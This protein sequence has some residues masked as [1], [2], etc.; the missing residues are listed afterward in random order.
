MEYLYGILKEADTTSKVDSH[1]VGTRALRVRISRLWNSKMHW[2]QWWFLFGDDT[3]AIVRLLGYVYVVLF[4]LAMS[5]SNGL[6]WKVPKKPLRAPSPPSPPPPSPP[7][8]RGRGGRAAFSAPWNYELG[9][10]PKRVHIHY[11]YGI[12]SQKP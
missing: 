10:G 6:F 1:F 11:S 12:R 3:T 9:A 5:W 7:P 8:C 4:F 2:G